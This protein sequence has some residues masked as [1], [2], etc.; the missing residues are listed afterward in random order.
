[1]FA[2][3]E[4]RDRVEVAFTDRHGGVSDGPYASFDFGDRSG[5]VDG[6]D[7]NLDILRHALA[8]GAAPQD[9][10]EA[11]DVPSGAEPPTMVL[12]RQVHGR[13][14]HVVDRA[15]LRSGSEAPTAD[16]LVTDLPGVGLVARAADCV[17][18]LVA[19]VEQGRVGA[20]HAGRNGMVA[21]V[22]PETVRALRR[23][24]ARQLVAW[25]GPHVCGRCYEVPEEMQRE[26]V[27]AF[28]AAEATTSWGTP[29][30]DIG[31]GVAW[32][33]EAEGV[34]VVRVARCTREDADLY[35]YRREGP[36]SG[37][38]AGVIWVRA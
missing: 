34:E 8:R 16:G 29:A 35:S 31:A 12:M 11:L 7:Q 3:T 30:L 18:V 13:D 25:V 4:T 28:P 17:P 10:E 21:G 33:L 38:L 1:M 32:Q 5:D 37:R 36:R 22:V 15:W 26:V 2:F 20:A 23:I 6:R 14:V 27:T 9:P 19:D 24:G